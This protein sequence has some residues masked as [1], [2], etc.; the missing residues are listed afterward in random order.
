MYNCFENGR[1]WMD[2]NGK[3]IQT[4]GF[5]VFHCYVEPLN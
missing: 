1:P 4:H 5:S 2:T 3:P